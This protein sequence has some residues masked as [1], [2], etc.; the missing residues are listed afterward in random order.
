MPRVM[1]LHQPV[2]GGVGRHVAD[3]A[4][5]LKARGLEVVLAG[6]SLPTALGPG[7]PHV[8]VEMGRAVSSRDLGAVLDFARAVRRVRPHIIHAH[9]SKAGAIA[10]LGRVAHP[11]VPV[12]YTPHGYAFSGHFSSALERR[13]YRDIERILA[14]ITSRV[15]CVCE[16][17]ARLARTIGP[18]GRVRVVHN[19][20]ERA[21]ERTV[22]PRIA[23]LSERGPVICALTLLR[24]GKGLE[25]L[26]DTMPLVLSSHPGAQV[27]IGGEG[28]ELKRLKD[29]A[30]ARKV[31]ESIHFLGP[32][33]DPPAML[34]GADVFVH[35]SWSEAFPYVILEAMSV[36]LAIVASDVG[37]IEEALVDGESGMLVP[38]GD[39]RSLAGALCSLLESPSLRARLGD[40]AGERVARHFTLTKMIDGM[41]SVYDEV[42]ATPHAP[43]TVSTAHA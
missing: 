1:L 14:L 13:S 41:L 12:I 26:I 36:G 43:K 20:I 5:G 22:D 37:G 15:V 30:S 24:P 31:A 8:R 21:G 32:I 19:G 9:S 34:R 6:P 3:L 39:E 28:P 25:T 4:A 10:R 35:P 33:D 29:R 2:D 16:A 7:H 42:L 38:A 18:P 40:M 23:A 11:S 27:A 17:E